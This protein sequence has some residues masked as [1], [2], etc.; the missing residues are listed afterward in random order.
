LMDGTRDGRHWLRCRMDRPALED[1][2][3]LPNRTCAD[4]IANQLQDVTVDAAT[5]AVV[6]LRLSV[7][8]AARCRVVVRRR[9]AT[10]HEVA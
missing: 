7:D 4:Y 2:R 8:D 10:D 1:V 6:P 5:E 9:R 3:S